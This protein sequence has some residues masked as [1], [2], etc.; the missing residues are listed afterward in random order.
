MKKLILC[1][2]LGRHDSDTLVVERTDYYGKD[3][4]STCARCR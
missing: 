2:I 4:L 1:L 3:F